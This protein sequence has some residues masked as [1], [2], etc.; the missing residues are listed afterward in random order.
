M[1]N[2]S[3][4]VFYLLMALGAAFMVWVL[5]S[6]AMD[7]RRRRRQHDRPIRRY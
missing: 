6:T 4:A 1:I 2:W 7:E 5:W 3:A